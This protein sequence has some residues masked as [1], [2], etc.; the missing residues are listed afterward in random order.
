[1]THDGS[2][3]G[4]GTGT[5]ASASALPQDTSISFRGQQRKLQA[6][7]DW[8]PQATTTRDGGDQ[9]P[10]HIAM[11]NQQPW[12]MLEQL[13]K[14]NPPSIGAEHSGFLPFQLAAA[15]DSDVSIIYNLLRDAPELVS[16]QPP[17]GVSTTSMPIL[18]D[19]PETTTR[20]DLLEY[21][22]KDAVKE[23]GLDMIS[24]GA[25][26]KDPSVWA[27]F[28]Q[29]LSLHSAQPDHVN[30]KDNDNGSYGDE[31]DDWRVVHAAAEIRECPVGLI[32]LVAIFHPHE[33]SQ[34]DA[35]TGS[36]PLHLVASHTCV[37]NVVHIWSQ[38]EWEDVDEDQE[39]K[40]TDRVKTLLNAYPAAAKERDNQGRLP[41]HVAAEAGQPWEA[42]DALIHAS[43]DALSERDDRGLFP[44][45]S[46]A[47]SGNATVETVYRLLQTNPS[48]V[49]MM[50]AKA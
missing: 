43:P 9:L 23:A 48:L 8:F 14:A 50:T 35:L 37:R 31:K 26:S 16:Q 36:L 15:A 49:T 34:R 11:K 20:K 1:M 39:Q 42:L 30:G 2:K 33:L 18:P 25:L 19:R 22:G 12:A 44:F 13:M 40:R 3:T 24:S 29:I 17:L 45:Q 7:I 32:R 41:L 46:A 4:T 27:K 21:P 5:T 38:A 10:L 28:H 47:A 6:L